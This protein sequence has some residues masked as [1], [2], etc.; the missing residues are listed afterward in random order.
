MPSATHP[1]GTPLEALANRKRLAAE[2]HDLRA[3]QYRREADE[4]EALARLRRAERKR[5]S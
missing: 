2:R 1:L 3:A 4:L 5:A